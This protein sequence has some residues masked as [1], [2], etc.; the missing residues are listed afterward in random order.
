M[1]TSAYFQQTA[2]VLNLRLSYTQKFPHPFTRQSYY[3]KDKSNHQSQSLLL[4]GNLWP[5]AR[6]LPYLGRL[7][8]PHCGLPMHRSR[9]PGDQQLQRGYGPYSSFRQLHPL[10]SCPPLLCTSH[11]SKTNAKCFQLL[12]TTILPPF[13][14]ACLSAESPRCL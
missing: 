6:N 12:G 8:G 3:S 5:R 14:T 4:C 2:L 1:L 9:I 11:S 13:S 7:L 10:P